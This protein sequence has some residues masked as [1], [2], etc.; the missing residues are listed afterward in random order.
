MEAFMVM[1]RKLIVKYLALSYRVRLFGREFFFVRAANVV[2]P[3]MLLL[4]YALIAE[5]VW[6]KWLALLA[7]AVV[8]LL[9]IV[10]LKLRPVVWG[11]L[12]DEQR[13]FYG[14]GVLSGKTGVVLTNKQLRQWKSIDILMRDSRRRFY[15]VGAFLV[16]IIALAVFLLM[17]I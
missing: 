9:V 8:W 16:N 17:L 6:L 3:L 15:G 7:V 11:E 13:W 2:V 4:G 10:Y 5:I 14:N 12:D 1:M